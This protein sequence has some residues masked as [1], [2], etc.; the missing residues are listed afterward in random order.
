ME[1]ILICTSYP[2]SI[3]L[4]SWTRSE[5]HNAKLKI[6]TAKTYYSNTH[7]IFQIHNTNDPVRSTLDFTTISHH[8]PVCYLVQRSLTLMFTLASDKETRDCSL[9]ISPIYNSIVTYLSLPMSWNINTNCL[10]S[11]NPPQFSTSKLQHRR[12]VNITAAK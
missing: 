11:P 10:D 6:T 12:L 8:T 5:S 7:Y 3:C 4:L 1:I 9:T 2:F